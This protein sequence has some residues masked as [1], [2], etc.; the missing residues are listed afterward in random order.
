MI[1]SL[2]Q[3]SLPLKWMKLFPTEYEQMELSPELI[4]F[5]STI[6]II[7]SIIL[8]LFPYTP[9]ALWKWLRLKMIE[10]LEQVKGKRDVQEDNKIRNTRL[11]EKIIRLLGYILFVFG[12]YLFFF[13][14]D[15]YDFIT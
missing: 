9:I 11:I 5:F 14:N 4:G 15:F 8:I 13:A 7:L 2:L 3:Q 1:L 6:L 10:Y 12:M